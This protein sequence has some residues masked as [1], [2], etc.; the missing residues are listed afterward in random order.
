[1]IERP[2]VKARIFAAGCLIVSSVF[3]SSTRSFN[4]DCT[5]TTA[6]RFPLL[7]A[8]SMPSWNNWRCLDALFVFNCIK[9]FKQHVK[10]CMFILRVSY[11]K[12]FQQLTNIIICYGSM[13]SVAAPPL[14]L[15]YWCKSP[16]Y[17]QDWMIF[18][19]IHSCLFFHN[20]LHQIK[21]VFNNIVYVFEILLPEQCYDIFNQFRPF[22]NR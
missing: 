10:Y 22:Q 14:H 17:C 8:N 16:L 9:A 4:F 21:N 13:I 15:I 11:S 1:M 19:V 12:F 3:L 18:A 20:Q 5:S 7:I 6:R 2:P